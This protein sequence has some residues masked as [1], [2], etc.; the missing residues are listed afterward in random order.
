[1][2][3]MKKKISAVLAGTLML[4]SFSTAA[5]AAP[6]AEKAIGVQLDGQMITLVNDAE[7]VINDARVY[8]PF[9]SLFETLG[10]EVEWD[11]SSGIISAVK[12][13]REVEFIG[14][15]PSVVIKENNTSRIVNTS[16]APY[17]ENGKTMIPVRFAGE[18]L[19]Y[20]IGWDSTNKTVVMMD[21]EKL[22]A[23]YDGQ[24]TYL[25]KLL[26]MN[27]DY[28]GKAVD[29]TATSNFLLMDESED[30]AKTF[31]EFRM[32]FSGTSTSDGNMVMDMTMTD[33]NSLSQLRNLLG[34]GYTQTRSFNGEKI[35]MDILCDMDNF[36]VYMKCPLLNTAMGMN[37]DADAYF[38]IDL[39]SV[40]TAEDI[41][42]LKNA[43]K[44]GKGGIDNAHDYIVYMLN[45][46]DMDSVED[47]SSFVELLNMVKDNFS[48]SAFKYD[49]QYNRYQASAAGI[50][51]DF[52]ADNQGNIDNYLV[53]V[54]EDNLN[55]TMHGTKDNS[56]F[57]FE[58]KDYGFNISMDMNMNYK[59]SDVKE[60]KTNPLLT[61]P[62][63]TIIPLM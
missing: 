60:L 23:Q 14:N 28:Q 20:N 58:M 10:A 2:K 43:L 52:H 53:Q 55:V 19:G 34:Q 26:N 3:S 11:Q 47:Y 30:A 50:S 32:E 36:V 15:Q 21:A 59:V 57:N 13:G 31:Y 48:D 9:R 33:G 5:L 61:N 39:K 44:E 17:I 38:S 62:N 8:L 42:V 35:T 41:V 45:N 46:V 25:E 54:N 27:K 18:A 63:A 6:Q 29:Y 12:D 22:A 16:A 37:A 56:Y 24:F 7:P 40:L 4:G 49:A 51:L 1:M